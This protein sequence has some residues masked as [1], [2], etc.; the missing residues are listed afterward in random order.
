M[1]TQ[2]CL[3]CRIAVE[4]VPSH[5]IMEDQKN[6]AF[7]DIYPLVEGQ[8][9]VIPKQHFDGY[10]FDMPEEDFKELSGF[11]GKV[12]K[13]IDKGLNVKRSMLVSQGFAIDHAHL[14][15]FPVKDVKTTNVD[16]KTYSTLRNLL[17]EQWY[18]GFV[19]SMSGKE[20]ESDEKLRSIANKIKH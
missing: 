12:G 5:I 6:M 16:E 11:A 8:T 13:L 19:I 18:S 17:R 10:A 1:E 15:L 7:L 20:R 4:E 3:F 2:K 14:K 9:V